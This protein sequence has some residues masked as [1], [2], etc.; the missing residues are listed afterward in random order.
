MK[1]AVPLVVIAALLASAAGLE[2]YMRGVPRENPLGRQLL[3]IPSAD[4]LKVMS[5]GNEG[6]L[7]DYIYI[8][9]IQY[10]AQF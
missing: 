7:A 6:F 8:W 10:F 4:Y 9:A 3:Y 5:L 2:F 1:S